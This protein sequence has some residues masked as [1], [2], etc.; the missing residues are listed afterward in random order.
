MVLSSLMFLLDPLLIK[1]LIDKVLPRRNL[2]LLFFAATG[3]FVIYIGRLGFASLARLVSFRSVQ[4]LVF[5][6]RSC[7]LEKMNQLSADYHEKTPLGEKLFRLEQDVDQLS[8]I[9][10]SLVPYVL[11]ITF[12]SVFVVGVMC[13]LNWRLTCVV[14]PLL[15]MFFIFRKYFQGQLRES[16]DLAQQQSSRESSFLQE[17][18]TS[19][20]QI[21]LLHQ[22]RSQTKAF[23]DR[24]KGRI[25]AVNRRTLVEIWFST[26]YMVIIALGTI[27]ILGYGGYQVFIGSLTIGGLVAFY[28]YLARLFDPLNAAVEIYSRLNRMSANIRRILEVLETVPSV[29]EAPNP[30]AFSVPAKGTIQM[31]NVCFSYRKD[32]DVLRGIDLRIKGGERVA[33]AGLNGS[34]K[35]TITKLIARIYDVNEGAVFIDG[36]DVRNLRLEDMRT[37]ICY[38]MQDVVLFDRTLKENLLLGKPSATS[39]E[40]R[41]AVE[42]ACLED[43]VQRLPNGWDTT[44]GPGGNMLSGGER[45]RVALARAA[46]GSPSLLLLDEAT[47]EVDG[48]GERKIFANL[49]HRFSS[50]TFVLISHRLEA[51]QWVDRIIVLDQGT[52]CEQ[53]MHDDLMANCGFYTH[54]CTATNSSDN[55][56]S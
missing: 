16:S 9:G 49:S 13:A 53:G 21:Q 7:L 8:E 41:S 1:W 4:N 46:L 44:L 50:A 55:S 54:L 14:L 40:L 31:K 42:L 48:P 23:L 47:S 11:Q 39:D 6:I 29:R 28:S 24:S 12:N 36:I 52:V 20:I 2:H 25:D 37:K 45:Q 26:C 18:L 34:G 33:L 56:F 10:S 3:F 38:L 22:E 15:P 17:H 32:L 5:R 27:T 35:S 51:L 30:V 19:I 43:V